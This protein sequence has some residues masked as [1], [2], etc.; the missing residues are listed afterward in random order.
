MV[1]SVT[2]WAVEISPPTATLT[3]GTVQ[4]DKAACDSQ[5]AMQLL[6][7]Q[8]DGL[9]INNPTMAQVAA[10]TQLDAGLGKQA[11]ELHFQPASYGTGLAV[12]KGL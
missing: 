2:C 3:C 10:I 12:L 11:G 1:C 6:G 7:Q 8:F 5:Q 9:D 4:A